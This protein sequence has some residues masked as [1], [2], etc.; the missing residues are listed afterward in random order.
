MNWELGFDFRP[1]DSRYENT[2]YGGHYWWSPDDERVV[3]VRGM[4]ALE[5]HYVILATD[6]DTEAE[7]ASSRAGLAIPKS[8]GL[9][10]AKQTAERFLEGLTA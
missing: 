1:D 4:D 10:E 7:L 5:G 9:E 3:I 2:Y 6:P 8:Q